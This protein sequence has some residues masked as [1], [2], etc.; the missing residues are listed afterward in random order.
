MGCIVLFPVLSSQL[1]QSFFIHIAKE[2]PKVFF[3]SG[4]FILQHNWLLSE[5]GSLITMWCCTVERSKCS[6]AITKFLHEL[7]VIVLKTITLCHS[8]YAKLCGLLYKIV[9]ALQLVLDIMLFYRTS[10]MSRTTSGKPCSWMESF[11]LIWKDREVHLNIGKGFIGHVFLCLVV[12]C[13]VFFNTSDYVFLNCHQLSKW[14]RL[15]E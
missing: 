1:S 15:A 5:Y 8:W 7:N 14:M 3:S 6:L 13:F 11:S 10:L 9:V 4:I 12:Q 2:F